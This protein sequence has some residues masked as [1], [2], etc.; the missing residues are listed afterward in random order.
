MTPA[1]QDTPRSDFTLDHGSPGDPRPAG[2][3]PSLTDAAFSSAVSVADLHAEW[4]RSLATP[5][6]RVISYQERTFLP[7]VGLFGTVGESRWRQQVET[8][9]TALCDDLS[10]QS[11]GSTRLFNPQ[12]PAG[13][14]TPDD[15]TVEAEHL[16]KDR[17]ILFGLESK[18]SS[19]GSMAELG[20]MAAYCFLTSRKTLAFIKEVDPTLG[21]DASRARSLVMADARYIRSMTPRSFEFPWIEHYVKF[22]DSPQQMAEMA[23][24]IVRARTNSPLSS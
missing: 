11:D 24:A 6:E 10:L 7:V 18:Y 20:F 4:I 23:T 9:Y 19:V 15:A 12:K 5:P 21:E 3:C 22:A 2:A 13:T 1:G 8:L 16:A 14:W 17:L